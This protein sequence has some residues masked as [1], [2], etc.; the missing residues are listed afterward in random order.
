ME[1]VAGFISAMLVAMT[2]VGAGILI[3]PFLLAATGLPPHQAVGTAL[4]YSSAI[5]LFLVPMAAV[6]R[7]VHWRTLVWMLAGGIPGVVAGSF[8]V[9]ALK[10]A[11]NLSG[12]QFF[13]GLIIASVAIIHWRASR[14]GVERGSTN[15]PKMLGS[16]MGIVGVEVGFSSAGAGALG[17]LALMSLTTLT[18][19]EVVGTDLA[20]GLGLSVIGGGLHAQAGNLDLGVAMKLITGGLAGAMVGAF[21]TTRVKPASLRAIVSVAVFGAGLHLCWKSLRF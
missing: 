4:V 16:L 13:L 8:L 9:R 21:L 17:S 5:K 14:K 18:T 19:A 12:L 10:G 20:F 6:R 3:V 2:G 15:R 11:G 7:Q 1:I